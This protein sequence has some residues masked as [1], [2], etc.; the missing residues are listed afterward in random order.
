VSALSVLSA[1]FDLSVEEQAEV[2]KL[3]SKFHKERLALRTLQKEFQDLTGEVSDEVVPAKVI[4]L[5][6]RKQGRQAV[7]NGPTAIVRELLASNPD[8]SFQEAVNHAVSVNPSINRST[9][10]ATFYAERRK[11]A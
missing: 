2:H 5:L 6:P 10:S 11:V 7:P 3:M 4:P 8:I 1:Y 9:F